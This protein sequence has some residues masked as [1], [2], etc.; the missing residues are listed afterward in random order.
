MIKDMGELRKTAERQELHA[1]VDL[2]SD[3]DLSA[4]RKILRVLADPVW[5]S[6]LTA[7]LDDEPETDTERAD[8]EAARKENGAGSSHEDVLHEFGV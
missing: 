5:Q 2:I 1:L 4:A 7:P 3:S 6:V 8:V